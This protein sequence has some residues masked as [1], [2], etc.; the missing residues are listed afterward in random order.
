MPNSFILPALMLALICG[1]LLLVRGIWRLLYG[2][3]KKLTVELVFFSLAIVATTSLAIDAFQESRTFPSRIAELFTNWVSLLLFAAIVFLGYRTI[4]SHGEAAVL[5]KN[6]HSWILLLV[7]IFISGWS[8]H[9]IQTRSHYYEFLGAAVPIPGEVERDDRSFGITDK[10][11]YI[12]LY[13]LSAATTAFEAYALTSD[14]K[15]KS[16]VHEGI[17][18]DEP[19]QNANCHGWVFTG[20][21]FL[22]KGNDV[23]VILTDNHYVQVATPEPG[24]VVI[25]RDSLNRILHTALVQGI[26]R[27]GTIIS[28]SKWGVDKRYLHLPSDQPYSSIYQYYRTDR[29]HHLIDI[30]Y[31]AEGNQRN[32][33]NM[34]GG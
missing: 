1:C 23:D 31:S 33:G 10:G 18:R 2:T 22:M 27:D 29:S 7:A 25:Y 21:R 30:Q 8:Y 15:Y 5:R 24:D 34:I 11:N 26:L 32:N 12:A 28:E 17:Q 19:D 14:E 3:Q 16:F 13:R 20:G 6:I 4:Q 9:R